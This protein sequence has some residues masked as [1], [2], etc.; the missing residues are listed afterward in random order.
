MQY[1]GVSVRGTSHTTVHSITMQ[2]VFVLALLGMATAAWAQTEQ[3]IFVPKD[4]LKTVKELDAS[5]YIGRWF[6][7]R[8]VA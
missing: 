7:V 5:K 2:P 1:K 8:G 6:Q 3:P 4:W